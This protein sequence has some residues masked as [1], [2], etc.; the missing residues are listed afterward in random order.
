VTKNDFGKGSKKRREAALKAA[1]TR[2]RNAL[3]K[4]TIKKTSSS[5][6]AGKKAAATRSHNYAQASAEEKARIDEI[7]HQAAIK[8]QQTRK[9]N[10]QTS[11]P[12]TREHRKVDWGIAVERAQ[13]TGKA[14]LEVTKWRINQ[15]TSTTKWKLV[16]FT[17]E[18]G[19]EAVGIVDLL[20]I[21]KNHVKAVKKEGLKP[22]DLFDMVLIQ[23]KGG[24]ALWPSQKDIK[25]MQILARY[26]TADN[27]VL[28]NLKDGQLFF[29]RLKDL[30]GKKQFNSKEA[31]TKV[32]SPSEIFP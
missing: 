14:A 13:N 29:Y 22:G 24:G 9:K 11:K 10:K 17:G 12:Q 30:E 5:S 15:L 25:R 6:G 28:S 1:I 20:A 16:E 26:Y 27:V 18:K 3:K 2:R 21:R 23:V 31:W 7:R 4:K 8:A 19:H 32:T